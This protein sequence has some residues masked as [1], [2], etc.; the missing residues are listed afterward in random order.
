Y[1]GADPGRIHIGWIPQRAR[2]LVSQ[3]LHRGAD[4]VAELAALRIIVH[5]EDVQQMAPVELK[6]VEQPRKIVPV[7]VIGAVGQE[8]PSMLAA[9]LLIVAAVEVATPAPLLRSHDFRSGVQ[10]FYLG[11]VVSHA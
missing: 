4:V 3:K 9:V 6:V 7:R 1:G 5:A 8:A 10:G 11:G 2:R